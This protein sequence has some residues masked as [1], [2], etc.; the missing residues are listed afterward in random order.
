MPGAAGQIILANC[1]SFFFDPCMITTWTLFWLAGL[2]ATNMTGMRPDGDKWRIK[3]LHDADYTDTL[4]FPSIPP[5][6][7]RN[8][9][10]LY[11]PCKMEAVPVE[12]VVTGMTSR[13]HHCLPADTDHLLLIFRCDQAP[14]ACGTDPPQSSPAICTK[15]APARSTSSAI[16]HYARNLR[17]G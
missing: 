5:K 12:I 2:R 11:R 8:E 15:T 3:L 7:G 4:C 13:R 16:W 10:Y 14:Y 9:A 6:C 1:S 17:G